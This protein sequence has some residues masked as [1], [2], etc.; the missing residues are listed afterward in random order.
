MSEQESVSLDSRGRAINPDG[1][2]SSFHGT[3]ELRFPNSL[4][5]VAPE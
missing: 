3:G 4:A 2:A 1:G 5:D